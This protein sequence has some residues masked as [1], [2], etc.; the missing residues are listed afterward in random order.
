MAI[1]KKILKVSSIMLLLITIAGCGK[2]IDNSSESFDT[3]KFPRDK[4]GY[5]KS[6]VAIINGKEFSINN[7]SN[8]KTS[9]ASINTIDLADVKSGDR[10][11][12]ILP[13]YLPINLWDIEENEDID[14]LSYE[15]IDLSVQQDVEGKSSFVQKFTFTTNDTNVKFKWCNVRECGKSFSEKKKD[16][17]LQL[18]LI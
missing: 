3:A 12:V 16:S 6:N 11:E 15:K 14:L 1:Y 17:L 5:P 4:Q 9:D 10:I 2:K 8:S 7:L 18:N 13:Q